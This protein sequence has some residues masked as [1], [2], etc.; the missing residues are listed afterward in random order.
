VSPNDRD[1]FGQPSQW[2]TLTGRPEGGN[3]YED[4]VAGTKAGGQAASETREAIAN[5]VD[6]ANNHLSPSGGYNKGPK[7]VLL[8]SATDSSTL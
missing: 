5:K 7:Q 6:K 2:R 1:E 4:M 3:K 8:G